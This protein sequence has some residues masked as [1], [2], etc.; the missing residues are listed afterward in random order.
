MKDGKD[1]SRSSTTS[2]IH[3]L[4]RLHPDKKKRTICK[5]RRQYDKN[6]SKEYSIT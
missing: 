6:N 1:D 4:E 2:G 5:L 3:K